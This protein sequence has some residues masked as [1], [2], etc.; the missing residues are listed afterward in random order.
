MQIEMF[1]DSK[2]PPR[3]DN[4]ENLGMR[5]FALHTT[6]IEETVH[7]LSKRGIKCGEVGTDWLEKKYCYTADPDGLPVELH[8]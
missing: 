2:H 7:E 3:A 4:P 1:I 8:E 6:N 5:H